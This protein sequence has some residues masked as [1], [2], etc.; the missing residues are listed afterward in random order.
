MAAS[1]A[2]LWAAFS[3]GTGVDY[4]VSPAALPTIYDEQQCAEVSS[5]TFRQ[6]HAA[7]ALARH[8]LAKL[9]TAAGAANVTAGQVVVASAMEGRGFLSAVYRRVGGGIVC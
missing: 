7:D 2:R 9:I 1:E 3:N 4:D 8:F 5:D 6:G